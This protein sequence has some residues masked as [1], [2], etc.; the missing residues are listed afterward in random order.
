MS[1][2][3][4]ISAYQVLEVLGGGGIGV[5]YRARHRLEAKATKERDVAVKVQYPN[6]APAR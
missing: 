4:T 3:E 6:L 2:P 5:V 1:H